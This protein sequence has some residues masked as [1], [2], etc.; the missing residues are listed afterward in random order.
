MQEVLS[1]TISVTYILCKLSEVSPKQTGLRDCWIMVIMVFNSN[2]LFMK[3][4]SSCGGLEVEL[5]T[6][7]SLPSASADQILLGAMY[8]Y[9]TI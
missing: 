3:K 7:N 4:I 8:L 5:W 6:D 2:M 1:Q 9:G